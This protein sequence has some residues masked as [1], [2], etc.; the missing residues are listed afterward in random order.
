MPG[1]AVI[2]PC[3]LS[4]RIHAR[5]TPGINDPTHDYTLAEFTDSPRF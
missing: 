1:A 4:A 3:T 5:N 2:R